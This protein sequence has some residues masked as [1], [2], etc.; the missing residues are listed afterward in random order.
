[1]AMAV[2]TSATAD[3]SW[4]S[5]PT[6]PP[7]PWYAMLPNPAATDNAERTFHRARPSE[8]DR[9][10]SHPPTTQYAALDTKLAGW[11]ISPSR[12]RSQSPTA[13]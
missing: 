5:L 7:G 8:R 4:N 10:H 2:A 3:V 13:M 6:C 12:I 1:M 9:C 11:A